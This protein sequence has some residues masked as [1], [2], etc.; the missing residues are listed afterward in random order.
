MAQLVKLW[1]SV[2]LTPGLSSHWR[3]IRQGPCCGSEFECF[4]QITNLGGSCQSK[5][6]LNAFEYVNTPATRQANMLYFLKMSTSNHQ[7]DHEPPRDSTCVC[8]CS[9]FPCAFHGIADHIHIMIIYAGGLDGSM[10]RG[11][12]QGTT[13]AQHTEATK[14]LA[15]STKHSI[16][17]GLL[18]GIWRVLAKCS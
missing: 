5:L 18:L 9:F 12:A 1:L 17:G 11:R 14:M 13:C 15:S 16:Y 8:V 4:H 7:H 3:V 2:I 6:S 10:C